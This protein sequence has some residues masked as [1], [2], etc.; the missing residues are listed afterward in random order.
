MNNREKSEL[1]KALKIAV[2]EAIEITGYESVRKMSMFPSSSQFKINNDH[3]FFLK[4]A[5]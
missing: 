5:A 2:F 3:S 4:K 1:Y